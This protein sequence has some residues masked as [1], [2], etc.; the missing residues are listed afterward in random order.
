MPCHTQED[1]SAGGSVGARGVASHSHCASLSHSPPSLPL[2]TL[3]S[4]L[5]PVASSHPVSARPPATA[6]QLSESGGHIQEGRSAG[7]GAGVLIL[8]PCLRPL[9]PTP[10]CQLQAAIPPL[11]DRLRLPYSSVR[12]E[13]TPRRLQA[14]IPPLLDRL[15]LPYSSVRV[16]GTPRRV[17]VQVA[18]LAAWQQ[19]EQREVRG[20]PANK[21]FD[22][23]GKPTKALEGFCKRNAVTADAV[24]TRA[25]D[26]GVEYVWASVSEESRPAWAVLGEQLP[27]V[28]AGIA[29]PKTMRWNSQV[30][31]SRPIRW[32]LAM[33]GDTVVPFAYAGLASGNESW[34]LRNA[35]ETE[36]RVQ[37]PS[38]EE[39]AAAIAAAGITLSIQ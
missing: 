8:F 37:L 24:T 5:L 35:P 25:D 23:D 21:A 4:P 32:L 10:L 16:G 39:Y 33:H 11:L 15:R 9:L 29:F 13:G 7:G 12:V 22:K 19:C 34:L 2:P 20:P 27:A 31:F 38:A 6:L 30:A 14:A 18:G 36:T 17:A 1:R 3:L 28:I 26:K